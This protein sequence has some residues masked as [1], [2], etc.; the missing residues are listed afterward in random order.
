MYAEIIGFIA[1]TVTVVGFAYG[2]YR[3]LKGD[4]REDIYQVKLEIRE[5]KDRQN[6]FENKLISMEERMFLLA[7]GKTIS[8]AILEEKLKEK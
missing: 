6:F 3:N 4:L 1:S 8:Q 5:I 2:F 7:T